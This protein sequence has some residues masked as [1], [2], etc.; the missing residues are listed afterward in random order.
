MMKSILFVGENRSTTAKQ[1]NWTWKDGRLAAKPLF[2]ALERLSIDPA[3]QHFVNLYAD[4][5]LGV[6]RVNPNT[7]RTLRTTPH[8][9]VALGQR[10]ARGLTDLGISHVQLVHPA[11]RGRIRKKSRYRAHVKA[12][13][14]AVL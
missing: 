9:V 10:V 6:F 3:K 1:K 8:I 5:A 7:V 2:E 13:L 12:A 4:G 14:M 11:A